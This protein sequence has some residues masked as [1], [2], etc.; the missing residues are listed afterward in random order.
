MI[1]TSR[2]VERAL[3]LVRLLATPGR[4]GIALTD[5]ARLTGM[6]HSTVHRLLQR[7][8]SE[9]LARQLEGSKRYALGS[10]A[11]EL[12][13]AAAAQ[14]DIWQPARALM[15]AFADEVGETV[16]LVVRSGTE[17]VCIER[18]EGPSPVRVLTLEAGS[19]RPLGLGAGG[20][21]ILA[22]LPDEEREDTI[23][24][25]AP[26]ILMQGKLTKTSLYA[27]IAD[28][29]RNGYAHVRN[30]VT[31]G[32]SAVGVHIGDTLGCPIAAISVAAI[33]SRM[34][35]QRIATLATQLQGTAK[36]IQ[37]TLKNEND[38]ATLS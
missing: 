38:P 37:H 23:S 15:R 10:L 13:V 4:R 18:V 34:S 27:S 14:F 2:S 20:L 26:D 24:S 29:Q 28:Y 17:A 16:Y 32:T 11:F 5:L 30:R 8:I 7:L 3:H 9:R 33:D 31:L 19:R 12:G 36:Q 1:A 35:R 25:I 22:A 21:A 6:S